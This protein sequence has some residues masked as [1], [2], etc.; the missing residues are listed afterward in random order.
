MRASEQQTTFSLLHENREKGLQILY[1]RYG[2][3]LYNYAMKS[4]HLDEDEAS[5]MVFQTLF[6]VASNTKRYEFESEK[7]FGNF[8]FSIF[9]NQLRQYY[10]D[11]KRWSGKVNFY[12]FDESLFDESMQDVSL[13]VEREIQKELVKQ[14]ISEYRDDSA[15]KNQYLSCLSEVL[16]D[17]EDWERIILLQRAQ[18]VPYA[19]ISPYIDK[20]VDQLKVYHQRA[21]KKLINLFTGKLKSIGLGKENDEQ[22]A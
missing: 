8:V 15:K 4:W 2:K 3:R 12:S 6:K 9:C 20:P 17:M 22:E 18:D 11:Q 21:R 19:E 7:K 13:H 14:F 1:E 16:A 5:E 10:R